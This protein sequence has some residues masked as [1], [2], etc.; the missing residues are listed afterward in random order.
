MRFPP[1]VSSIVLAATLAGAGCA[2]PRPK[3]GSTAPPAAPART[4]GTS[5]DGGKTRP[6]KVGVT[7]RTLPFTLGVPVQLPKPRTSG[8]LGLFDA[9]RLRRSSR[10]YASTPLPLDRLSNLLWA[11]TGV[12]RPAS[13]KRTT[14][15]ARNHRDTDVYVATEAGLYLYDP[16]HHALIPKVRK[17]LRALT[18]KQAFVGQAPLNLVYVVDWSR[19]VRADRETQLRYAGAHAAFMSQNLYL[20]CA[21]EKLATVVRASFDRPALSR[22]LGLRETQYVVLAQTVGYP[23]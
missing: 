14:P 3:C 17:D 12:N 23:K 20:F 21:A 22:A 8:G 5:A 19:A 1:L 16:V 15:F 11:T 13:G 18:G 6:A 10:A 4:N 2:C 7:T 9:L